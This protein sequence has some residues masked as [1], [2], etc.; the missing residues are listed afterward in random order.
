MILPGRI[1]YSNGTHPDFSKSALSWVFVLLCSTFYVLSFFYESSDATDAFSNIQADDIWKIQNMYAQ[2]T[3]QIQK[4][5]PDQDLNHN[6][7]AFRDSAFWERSQKFS[8]HGDAIQIE[9]LKAKLAEARRIYESSI[10]YEF[11]LGAEATTPLAWI[12]YQ[13]VHTSG[14]HLLMNM[15]FLIF[16]C[17]QLERRMTYGWIL[18]VYLLSGIGA[19]V[20]YLLSAGQFALAMIGASGSIS[21][22]MGF[23][24]V[25]LYNRS[26]KWTYLVIPFGKGFGTIHMPGVFIFPVYLV[27]DFTRMLASTDGLQ[28]IVAHSAHVGGAL[29]GLVIG[30]F[31]LSDRK[32]K[33]FLIRK[34]GKGLTSKELETLRS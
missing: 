22:L 6:L 15:I 4:F 31:Y 18:S 5:I 10:S 20:L 21:G 32:L 27:A 7:R 3:D 28:S 34:W 25:V 30:F 23:A 9:K 17:A 29:T 19:G 14:M 24:T 26:I 16:I 13:F 2:S 11:G 1:F 8:F 12:T 33:N